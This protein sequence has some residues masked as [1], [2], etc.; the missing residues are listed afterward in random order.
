MV[1]GAR[2]V[3]MFKQKNI[4]SQSSLSCPTMYRDRDKER[5]HGTGQR[6]YVKERVVSVPVIAL[7]S[8][9][10]VQNFWQSCLRSHLSPERWEICTCISLCTW[11]GWTQVSLSWGEDICCHWTI[12]TCRRE[13]VLCYNPFQRVSY[14]SLV[15]LFHLELWRHL[16]A[17]W[18]LKPP[19]IQWK[20]L[21]CC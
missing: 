16:L 6:A 13:A 9:S 21:F 8:I 7:K 4:L 12:S 15:F 1:Y 20:I 3:G 17:A 10:P 14:L 11:R 18:S 19:K 2:L 5:K